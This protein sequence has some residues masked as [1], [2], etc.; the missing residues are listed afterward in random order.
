MDG[1][2]VLIVEGMS[3]DH[4]TAAVTRAVGAVAGVT[5]VK[6]DLASGRVTLETSAE[7]SEEALRKAVEG[8]GYRV[9]A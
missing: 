4:C 9:V 1:Q 3:C 7:V 6:V 2:K 5:G 8:A